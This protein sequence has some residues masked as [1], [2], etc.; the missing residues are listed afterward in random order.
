MEKISLHLMLLEYDLKGLWVCLGITLKKIQSFVTPMNVY[1][2]T[3][4]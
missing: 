4:N 3:K 2:Y 1:P